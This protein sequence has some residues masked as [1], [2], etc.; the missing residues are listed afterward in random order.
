M[1]NKSKIPIEI[2][3]M[4]G[5]RTLGRRAVMNDMSEMSGVGQSTCNRIFHDFVYGMA[6][7]MFKN[8]VHPPEGDKLKEVMDQYARLGFAGAVGS[9]DCTHI[10]WG[11]CPVELFHQCKGKEGY[12]SLAFEMVV[13]HKRR[14]H[15]CTEA[16]HGAVPDATIVCD[17]E[18]VSSILG[19]YY[20]DV[21]YS[22]YDSDGQFTTFKGG[23]L[24]SDGGY[25]NSWIFMKP[26]KRDWSPEE[27]NIIILYILYT[28]QYIL[29]NIYYIINV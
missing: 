21:A 14:F 20:K 19:G 4:I 25:A 16:Y 17:D 9:I 28:I 15:S 11:K 23:Y 18:Y 1:K 22:L 6:A 5:L 26:L 10:P 7:K 12:P 13:D 27:S 2:K 24:I 8:Y 3:L 29:Y